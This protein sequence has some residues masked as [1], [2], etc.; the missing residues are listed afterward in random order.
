MERVT[1]LYQ[2]ASALR[3]LAE[4]IDMLPI[5]DQL[6][7]LAARFEQMAKSMEKHPEDADLRQDE[8]ADLH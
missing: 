2:E 4:R 7:D 5:R 6:L 3:V 1:S 8:L